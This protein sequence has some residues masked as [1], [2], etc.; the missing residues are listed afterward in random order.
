MI[1]LDLLKSALILIG[2]IFLLSYAFG[3]LFKV[4]IILLIALGILYLV[5]KVF[6]E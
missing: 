1:N 3:F 4:G 2:I 5:K 6:F